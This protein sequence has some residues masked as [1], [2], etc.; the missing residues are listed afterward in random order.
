[1]VQNVD[2]LD[3]KAAPS[4][5]EGYKARDLPFGLSFGMLFHFNHHTRTGI[6]FSVVVLSELIGNPSTAE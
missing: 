5:G 3:L 6:S 1:M 2:N 4:K